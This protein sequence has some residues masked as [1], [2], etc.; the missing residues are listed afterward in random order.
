VRVV[1]GGGRDRLTDASVGGGPVH[2]YD[3][4]DG[5]EFVRGSRTRVDGR[6][7]EEPVDVSSTTHQAPARDWGQRWVALPILGFQPDLGVFV[8]AW[9]R[10][11]SYGFRHYPHKSRVSARF[12]LGAATVLP[13]GEATAEIALGA[14]PL[15]AGLDLAYQG[16]ELTRFYG[17]GNETSA[18]R[19][20]A[21]YEARRAAFRA[22]VAVSHG[23]DE[24]VSLSVGTTLT[25]VRPETVRGTLVD[26][27]MPYGHEAF[28]LLSLDGT[29]ELNRVDDPVLPRA[30]SRLSLSGRWVPALLDTRESFVELDARASA[31][32][33]ADVFARPT[34][35]LRGGAQKVWGPAPYF[36]APSLGGPES[37]RGFL[38]HR[39]T[40]DAAFF[41]GAE[42]RAEVADFVFLLPGTL[43]VLGLAE[44]GRVTLDGETSS[45]WH[46]ALGGGIWASLVGEYSFSLAFA[47]SAER[48]TLHLGAGMPF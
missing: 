43:G 34:L 30:G 20:D 12:A 41:A 46:G 47:R 39:F 31:Y 18:S 8:G 13:N 45:T 22:R 16:A 1:G 44:T 23:S 14:T 48:T 4:G 37:L 17:F 29:L 28:D 40:G 25:A 36:E 33:S 9:L 21:F 32:L 27:L 35:A 15:R 6:D 26:S 2:L 10:R 42:L 11:T 7:W 24:G 3:A 19:A 38:S 5:T